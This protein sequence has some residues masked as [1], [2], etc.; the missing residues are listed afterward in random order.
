MAT[1]TFPCPFCA[2][3]MGVGAELL[4][5]KVRCPHCK[6][7]VLAPTA[8]QLAGGA[9]TPVPAAPPPAPVP[10]APAPAPAPPAPA[11]AAPP[12]VHADLP[13]FNFPP[14]E[15]ADSIFG[16][17]HAGEDDEVFGQPNAVRKNLP[18]MPPPVAPLPPVAPPPPVVAVVP[19]PALVPQPV[20]VVAHAVPSAAA[21]PWAAFDAPAAAPA[22]PPAAPALVPMPVP[23]EPEET[24][25]SEPP[26]PRES[27]RKPAKAERPPADRR[28][29]AAGGGLLK[30][31]FYVL[32]AYSL[33][34]TAGAVYGLFIKSGGDAPKGHP[35]ST[36]PDDFGGFDP[37]KRTKA[38]PTAFKL[39]GPLP[40]EL[41]VA[42]GK[43]VE[44]GALQVEPTRIE[45]RPLA[46]FAETEAGKRPEAAGRYPALVLH[47][48]V[49]NTSDDVTL[50][51]LDPAFNRRS[52]GTDLAGTGLVIDG[53]KYWG[54][55]IAWPFPKNVARV[56]EKAQEADAT[57]LG[58]KEEREYVVFTETDPQILKK[59]REA[60]GPLLWR[61]Q[62]RS[63][64][65]E[66]R[67]KDVPVS[68]VIGVEFTPGD[69]ASAG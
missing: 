12:P 17:Q 48:R 57:P 5:H 27:R 53:Q 9:P 26:A 3:K 61:V 30:V 67:G 60:K 6:N 34:A 49:R 45:V 24:F 14:Q 31:G 1:Q 46:L 42:F 11:P 65:V 39:D 28:P 54:G 23:A 7:V 29:A 43:K 59:V 38:G 18:E 44:V 36:I 10:P 35:L 68:S 50:H 33:L 63:G 55:A 21:N 69:V 20:A 32:L 37:A 4:G 52:R 58:P 51:P 25:D 62:L 56:Y 16:E 47:L 19:P 2:K 8:A 13:V 15:A 40:P 22:P 66:Y 41:T 64:L